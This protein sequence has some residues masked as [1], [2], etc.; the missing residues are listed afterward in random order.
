MLATAFDA[1][2]RTERSA[3]DQPARQPQTTSRQ[4]SGPVLARLPHEQSQDAGDADRECRNLESVKSVEKN[5]G[6][7]LCHRAHP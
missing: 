3:S 1:D 5:Q 2:A 7:F 6:S 4:G